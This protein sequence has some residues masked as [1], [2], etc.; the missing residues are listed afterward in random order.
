MDLDSLLTFFKKNDY[1]DSLSKSLINRDNASQ[2]LTNLNQ[3]FDEGEID[4]DEFNLMAYDYKKKINDSNFEISQYKKEIQKQ[5]DENAP[6]ADRMRP[7]RVKVGEINIDE[8]QKIREKAKKR[9][10]KLK[11]K[12]DSLRTFISA[13]SITDLNMDPKKIHSHSFTKG[14]IFD[15]NITPNIG[16]LEIWEGLGK[17]LVLIG[18]V[19]GIISIFLPW[20]SVGFGFFS[21]SISLFSIYPYWLLFLALFLICLIL[22]FKN[23]GRISSLSHIII[24]IFLLFVMYTVYSE[25]SKYQGLA[26]GIGS[27]GELFADGFSSLTGSMITISYGFYIEIIC[28]FLILIGGF[29]E[30]KDLE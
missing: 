25:V 17:K 16:N 3:L 8:F 5:I 2:Y 18:S 7:R 12:N 9:A 14:N 24:G 29:F 27:I 1:C 10:E 23:F 28:I 22:I 20:L 13:E 4:Q 26:Q 6:L 19:L 15:L 11:A 30:F 21:Q